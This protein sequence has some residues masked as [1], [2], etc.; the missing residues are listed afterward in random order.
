[1]N[2]S[3]NLSEI[4]AEMWLNYLYPE[5]ENQWICDYKGSFYRNYQ[6]DAMKVDEQTH[7]VDLSRDGILK[8]LPQG[9]LTYDDEL[10]SDNPANQFE[11][12]Q[13]RIHLLHDAFMPFDSFYFRMRLRME[14]QVSSLLETKL[15]FILKR[16]FNY[17]LQAV[18]NP[19][20]Q[21][22][23]PLLPYI[24]FYKGNLTFV[25]RLLASVLGTGVSMRRGRYSSD[26]TSYGWIPAV[27]YY[28]MMPGLEPASYTTMREKIQP[29]CDFIKEWLIP[30]EVHAE[31]LL[32]ENPQESA[33]MDN[34]VL[35]NYNAF[36]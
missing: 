10:K 25:K 36:L 30:F 3:Q 11:Q 29:L 7:I 4:S 17:D 16:F 27:S 12:M 23:V 15:N 21:E 6:S 22:V 24:S 32:K 5:L 2:I 34:R 9:F 31:I 33:K 26:D 14:R 19:F 18:T 28:V 20:L 35:L 1:M 13:Q 8:L